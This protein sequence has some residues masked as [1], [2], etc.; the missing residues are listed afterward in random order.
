MILPIQGFSAS[1]SVKTSIGSYRGA[2]VHVI[3]NQQM[4]L[5]ALVQAISKYPGISTYPYKYQL[6]I[7]MSGLLTVNQM[8]QYAMH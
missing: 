6:V 8:K 4:L 1:Q 7:F 5:V 2:R 3:V